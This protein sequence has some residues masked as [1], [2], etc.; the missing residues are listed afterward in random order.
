MNIAKR[1]EDLETR[2]G[3]GTEKT[4]LRVSFCGCDPAQIGP[5]RVLVPPVIGYD[6]PGGAQSWRLLEG[7]SAEALWERAKAEVHCRPLCAAV[8]LECYADEELG[9]A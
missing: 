7:E 2:M 9:P 1:L 6:T 8:L 4:V 3:T 5:G